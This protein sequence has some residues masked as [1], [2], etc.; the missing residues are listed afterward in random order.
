[1]K[2]TMKNVLAAGLSLAMMASL[3]AC[4]GSSAS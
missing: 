1:M 3:A 4:G 2:H